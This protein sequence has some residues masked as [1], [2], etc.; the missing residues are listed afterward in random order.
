[1][2]QTTTDRGTLFARVLDPANRP[3]PYPLY[4]RLREAPVSLQDDGTY[5]V[6]THTEV[7]RLLHDP[8]ISSDERKSEGGAG[9]LVAS[10]G[11]WPE[12]RE[13]YQPFIFLDPPDHDRLRRVGDE[14]VHPRAGEGA[15]PDL[16]TC[17]RSAR[18][19]ERRRADRR[20]GRSSLPAAGDGDLRPAR[21]AARR[22]A[23]LSRL[24]GG[25]GP[26]PGPRG[27]HDPKKR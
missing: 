1:M 11:L 3:D 2:S 9:A 22:R 25:A 7:A 16:P 18:G 10:G 5:V 17:K 14:A 19:T 13:S 12:G 24:G 27:G 20:R 6:S 26:E 21:R 4:A 8:R 23:T 15:G